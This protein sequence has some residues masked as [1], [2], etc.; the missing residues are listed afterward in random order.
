MYKNEIL[1]ILQEHPNGLRLRA[2]GMYMNVYHI[3]LVD[4]MYGM[5]D[6]GLVKSRNYSDPAN[7]EYYTIWSIA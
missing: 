1:K 3:Q 7:C 4:I 6:E 2:I 5:R